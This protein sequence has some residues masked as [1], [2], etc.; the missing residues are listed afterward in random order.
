MSISKGVRVF[1]KRRNGATPYALPPTVSRGA[2][3][4]K[5]SDRR[6]RT[7]VNDLFTIATRMEIVRGHL[8]KRMGLS[9]P[10]YSV[11][12]SIAHLQGKRGVSVG[13]LA[14]AMHVSS[15]FIASET[16]KLA[17]LGLLV[18]RAN[19]LDRRGVLLS[20]TPA[21]RLKIGR[22]SGEIRRIND[23]FFGGLDAA[24]FAALSAAASVL[25]KG[26]SRA[27]RYVRGPERES[28]TALI[29]AE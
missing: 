26:S 17:R 22:I 29:A 5:E 12:I 4:E 19:P 7:L 23:L 21:G 25:V 10:R 8:G 6:F 14:R 18:K 1:G 11:L 27:M 9:G 3:L 2:L 20:L 16:G 15:A 13:A 24:S 28:Q